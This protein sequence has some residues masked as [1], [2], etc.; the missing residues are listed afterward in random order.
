MKK[1]TTILAISTILVFAACK[2]ESIKNYQA[3]SGYSLDAF[4]GQWK[5]TK[6]TQTDED[7]KSKLFPYKT[8]DLTTFL[9]LTDIALNL[10]LASAV[11]ATFTTAY[12]NA[13]KI[14]KLTTGNWKLDD[15][16]KPGKLW[17]INGTDTTKFTIGSYNQLVNKKLVLKQVK[18]LGTTAVIT[19]EYEFSKN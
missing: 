16:N 14:F 6:A 2:P 4:Q 11:P 12:G 10:N 5:L 9:N 1:I 7:S 3:Y 8:L 18:Y 13:P 15:N 19:Y 17:L